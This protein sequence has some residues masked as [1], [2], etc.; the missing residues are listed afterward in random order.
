VFEESEK[1]E[2]E[3]WLINSC[4]VKSPSQSQM[5]TVI[6]EGKA[7]GAAIVVA[8]C[9]PQGDKKSRD[10]EVLNYHTACELWA[11]TLSL[12]LT[13]QH[14]AFSRTLA[15][16]VPP[17]LCLTWEGL[18]RL[19]WTLLYCS[20]LSFLSSV[21]LRST[22]RPSNFVTPCSQDSG[23]A[24]LLCLGFC[25]Q[26]TQINFF[27]DTQLPNLPLVNPTSDVFTSNVSMCQC[28]VSHRSYPHR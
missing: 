18:G 11:G 28:L 15:K 22:F 10:L 5:A 8:G 19:L 6:A 7:R 24:A 2:A 26:T 17:L 1:G 12:L 21:D 4:T 9:V 23:A 14:P 3:V 25:V 20:L 27:G 13:F 16:T